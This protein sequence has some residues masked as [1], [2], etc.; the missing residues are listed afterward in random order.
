MLGNKQE[1]GRKSKRVYEIYQSLLNQ[2]ITT[3]GDWSFKS[4]RKT[5][6][7]HCRM[8]TFY[9]SQKKKK[10]TPKEKI[11]GGDEKLSGGTWVS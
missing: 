6:G 4:Y 10:R 3:G 11:G 5:I 9:G 8:K 2:G 1:W 7:K